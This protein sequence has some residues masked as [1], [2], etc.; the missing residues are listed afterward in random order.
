METKPKNK[1]FWKDWEFLEPQE[2]IHNKFQ[3]MD[4]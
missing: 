3:K 1:S 4:S 2:H